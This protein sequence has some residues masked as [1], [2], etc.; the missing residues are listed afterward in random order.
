MILSLLTLTKPAK[1]I[2]FVYQKAQSF[3][4]FLG[5]QIE[6]QK[7]NDKKK[8]RGMN[9]NTSNMAIQC[10]RHEENCKQKDHTEALH[11]PPT[12]PHPVATPSREFLAPKMKKTHSLSSRPEFF[13]AHKF[14]QNFIK[15]KKRGANKKP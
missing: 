10:E 3:V 14:K 7:T 12:Y 2:R 8:K 9:A 6:K 15:K 13:L 11:L 4:L 5:S 1:T